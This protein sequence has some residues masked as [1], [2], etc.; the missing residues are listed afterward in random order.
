[1]KTKKRTVNYST[2]KKVNDKRLKLELLEVKLKDQLATK[3]ALLT[4]LYSRTNILQSKLTSLQYS[5]PKKTYI[6]GTIQELK[7]AQ[8]YKKN[9]YNPFYN[10]EISEN[11]NGTYT[12]T[13]IE[14]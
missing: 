7:Q 13:K 10:I 12:L 4:E 14:K 5:T 2:Y 3:T 1:M 11:E 9:Y 8:D 6:I